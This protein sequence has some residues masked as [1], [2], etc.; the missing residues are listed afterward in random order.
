MRGDAAGADS[1][2]DVSGLKPGIAYKL[3]RYDAMASV[4]NSK[5]NANAAKAHAS[6][7]VQISS[8]TIY[9]MTENIQSNE[10]AVYRAVPASAP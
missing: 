8:G 6:W 5:F 2:A 3:Y 1:I 4:P 7:D 9:Q 10:I